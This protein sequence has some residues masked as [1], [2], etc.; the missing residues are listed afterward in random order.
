[1][2]MKN[3]I[4]LVSH[5]WNRTFK[6]VCSSIFFIAVVTTLFIIKWMKEQRRDINKSK[7]NSH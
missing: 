5:W 3:V 1:M 4:K 6:I 7:M 2:L